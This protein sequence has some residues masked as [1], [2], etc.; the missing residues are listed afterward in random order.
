MSLCLELVVL[1]IPVLFVVSVVVFLGGGAL[2]VLMDSSK[3][4]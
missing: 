4:K 1:V 3:S 2:L